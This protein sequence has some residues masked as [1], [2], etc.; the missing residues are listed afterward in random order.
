MAEGDHANEPLLKPPLIVSEK[1]HL[2]ERSRRDDESYKKQQNG[3]GLSADPLAAFL[4]HCDLGEVEDF[5]RW[6]TGVGVFIWLVSVGLV[7]LLT[8]D[9]SFQQL[10]GLDLKASVALFL[11]LLVTNGSRFLPFLLVPVELQVKPSGI[12]FGC[13]AVQGIAIISLA[14]S[15]VGPAPVLAS[16]V[17]KTKVYLVSWAARVALRFIITFFMEGIDI[18]LHP[19]KE[20]SGLEGAENWIG[21]ST[22]RTSWWHASAVALAAAAGP[23]CALAQDDNALHTLHQVCFLLFGTTYVRLSVRLWQ[24][25]HTTQG[26]TIDSVEAF[27]RCRLSFRLMLLCCLTWTTFELKGYF[28][29]YLFP[30]DSFW[31]DEHCIMTMDRIYEGLCTVLYFVMILRINDAVFDEPSRAVRRLETLRTMMSAVWDNSSDIVVLCIPSASSGHIKAIVSPAFLKFEENYEHP[32]KENRKDDGDRFA[33]VLE[34]DVRARGDADTVLP[35]HRV[36]TVDLGKPI[37][38][39]EAQRIRRSLQEQGRKR[40]IKEAPSIRKRNIMKLT[41]LIAKAACGNNDES[42]RSHDMLAKGSDGLEH[43]VNCEANVTK[44]DSQAVLIVIRDISERFHRFEAE[45]QLIRE[46]TERKK[47]AEANRFIRHE[48]KNGLL[49]AIALIESL[50][51]EIKTRTAADIE[52]LG[53]DPQAGARDAPPLE[54]IRR[55]ELENSCS[56]LDGTLNGILETV[57][58]DAMSRDVVHDRYEP[59]LQRID[60]FQVLNSTK[61]RT[62]TSQIRFP[63]ILKPTPFPQIILDPRLLRFIHRNAVSNAARYGKPGGAITTRVSFEDDHLL[64]QVINL[65]GEEH[66]KLV[67]LC[68][69]AVARVFLPGTQLHQEMN[70]AETKDQPD[71]PLHAPSAGDGAWIMQKCAESMKGKC[72]IRFE[73][74]QTVFSMRCPAIAYVGSKSQRVSE[75]GMFSVPDNTFG[76]VIDDSGIQRK[77]MDRFLDMIGVRKSKRQVLGKDTEEILGL[78]EF[79]VKLIRAKP[80]STFLLIVDENLDIVDGYRHQTISG[81][82]LISQ[83]RQD[84]E[85]D[86]ERRILA[87]VRSANDS[88]DDVALYK[89]RAHGFLCKAP[90]KKESVVQMMSPV[91]KERFPSQ[92]NLT[93]AE[94]TG[95]DTNFVNVTEQ[96]T[97][98]PTAD[99][100]MKTINSIDALCLVMRTFNTLDAMGFR[101]RKVGSLAEMWP[102]LREELHKL[103]G[104]LKSF[105]TSPRMDTILA[106][107]DQLNSENTAEELGERWK[108]IRALILSVI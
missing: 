34:V 47:D 90:L 80:E 23:L 59:Y 41:M 77:L 79:L 58:D 67:E 87:L 28:L 54:V 40:K 29:A 84:L 56:E 92:R 44:L 85:P 18:P 91:W 51:C 8:P 69:D 98:T 75:T 39:E 24:L 30:L 88:A 14:L 89:S 78:R 50:Q 81:S 48:V 49:A 52:Y 63:I 5:L 38:R 57:L 72:S 73:P 10:E 97:F 4:D 17:S 33:L 103:K 76:I 96:M 3:L 82:Q 65:P 13:F 9:N 27:D 100:L 37:D 32:S 94:S 86:E 93:R 107:F 99:D 35:A 68:K 25:V 71:A 26:C 60:V 36:F 61:L 55:R 6:G 108:L 42:L 53:T 105:S 11:V 20:D 15:I 62:A 1:G 101:D 83:I 46:M 16:P 22:Q 45:K 12:L 31:K 74:N 21:S 70:H 64:L 102:P 95:S 43:V 104:D 19:R 2:P 7:Y 106:E 66:D